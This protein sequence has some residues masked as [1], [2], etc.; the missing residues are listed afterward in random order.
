MDPLEVAIHRLGEDGDGVAYLPPDGR[1]VHVEQALPGERVTIASETSKHRARPSSIA[2]PSPERTLPPCRHFGACGGCT[3]QHLVPSG[4]LAWKQAR[5]AQA[6][7]AAGFADPAFDPPFQS[8]LRTRRRMDLAAVRTATG[9]EVGLHRRDAREIVDLH[10]CVV[11]DPV[12]FDLI[13]PLRRLLP[14][15]PMATGLISLIVNR[16]ENGIDLLLETGRA[17]TASETQRLAAFT[18]AHDIARISWR[19]AGT[20]RQDPPE[21]LVLHRRPVVRFAGRAVEPP[22]GAFLQATLDAEQAMTGAVIDAIGRA[23][24]RRAHLVE[25]Y[26]GCGTFTFP[27]AETWG[28]RVLSFEGDA[29][30][31]AALARA[32]GGTRIETR[33][34]DLV[35][36]PLAAA[37]LKDAAVVLLDPPHAGASRQM[38]EIARARPAR[39]VMVSCNPASLARDAAVLAAS[40]YRLAT[41]R[42]F[43]Q[44]LFSARVE[45]VS[46]FDA[47]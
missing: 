14:T 39:V 10:E 37:E 26:A 38:G 6:L 7:A 31:H 3:L 36:Q 30:T 1:T 25:L 15:L 2:R 19:K 47:T 40:G 18:Q 22:P 17:S 28:S 27:A 23:R 44:F 4:N 11:L 16:C 43:D 45:S 5:V 20:H 13:A 42:V 34:R 21:T 24:T 41:S 33:R 9:I 46:V 35:R 32:A 29:D 12:L 8:G